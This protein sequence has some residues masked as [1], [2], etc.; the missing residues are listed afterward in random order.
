F[1]FYVMPYV[2]GETLRTRI[3][4]E[5]QLSVDDALAIT[6]R[7]AGALD[8]AHGNGVVHRDIKPA[9]ILL[10]AQG[11]PL[12]ADFGIAI[13][14]GAAGGSRL[15]ETG[16]S[17]GTPYYMSPEQA[18]GDQGVGA[19]S[20]MYALACVL[21]EMLVGEPPYQGSTAQA[22]LG[23]IIQ[24]GPVS[25]RDARPSVPLHVDAA[26]RKA[27]EKI[28]ADRFASAQDFAKALSNP[29]FGYGE[30]T[31][32]AVAAPAGPWKAL[33]AALTALVV[34]LGGYTAWTL[35]TPTPPPT[36]ERY[37]SPFLEGQEP[38]GTGGGNFVLSRDGSMAA[39]VGRGQDGGIQLWVRR[40]IDLEATPIR[41]TEGGRG[42][43]ISPDGTE[44]AFFRGGEIHVAPIDGGPVRT[45]MPGIVPVWDD[46]GYVYARLGAV[47]AVRVPAGGGP[48]DTLSLLQ[49]GDQNHFVADVLPDGEKAL[50]MVIRSSGDQE[51]RVLDLESGEMTFLV[52]AEWANYVD[53]GHLVYP[54]EGTLIA[55]PF[56]AGAAQITGPAVSLE[57]GVLAHSLSRDG[58]LLYSTGI[59][60]GPNRQLVWV[61][62]DG[63]VTPVDSTWT[64]T[65]GDDNLSWRIS[66]DGSRVV[67]REMTEGSYDLWVKELD[68]G[69]RSRLTFDEAGD[70]YPEWTPDGESVTYVSG[71]P[72]GLNVNT[73]RADGTGEPEQL[74]DAE[75]SIALAFWSPDEEWLILRSTTGAGNVFG[76]DILAMR[77][78]VD[79]APQPLIAEEF[80]EMDPTLSP[81][82]RW[83]AY[84][85]NETGRF[86]IYVRPF[87][88][89][90]SGRWQI[91]SRGGSRP[92]WS[93]DGRE[94]FFGDEND[95]MVVARVDG[96]GSAFVA[97]SPQILFATPEDIDLGDLGIPYDISP[98]GQR[99]MMAR[100]V[101]DATMEAS[102]LPDFVLVNNFAE[103]LRERVPN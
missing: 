12:V 61:T 46:H 33:T 101:R 100:I 2:D 95:N 70:Y 80:D 19:A 42:P 50:V 55:A 31:A 56:D 13:A 26:I 68:D 44:V 21:Y 14:V 63:D 51:I 89:V 1:L 66:P 24:G 17:V 25:A 58:R 73:R 83:L 48:P 29:S 43:D 102:G 62:R 18:T 93:R 28:P 74:V 45:L 41:G 47:G 84:A 34:L 59:S 60:G 4:R 69:P 27:L 65:R 64:F 15:T 37:G 97:E 67:L 87:P 85:S 3:E 91:S 71:T 86:E 88:D 94:I 22:V 16:L 90:D 81:D 54:F 40:W 78:G 96:S 99:F 77:P 23:K 79:A 53:S 11:E 8:Y 5:K 75:E 9:N 57:S 32:E 10:S 76:R 20:D 82:G 7:V 52:T 39:Y 92:V 72:T 35:L 6:R 38:L 103:V 98:D 30:E 36:V 49:E